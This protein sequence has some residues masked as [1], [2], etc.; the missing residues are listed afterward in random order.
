[1]AA[2]VGDRPGDRSQ[3]GRGGD[4]PHRHDTARPDRRP[5]QGRSSER[6]WPTPWVPARGDVRKILKDYEQR[7][8]APSSRRP[9]RRTVKVGEGRA[10]PASGDGADHEEA[11]AP[12]ASTTWRTC[13]RSPSDAS[14]RNG[15]SSEGP[16]TAW[17]AGWFG[18][19]TKTVD[20]LLGNKGITGMVNQLLT[21]VASQ[22]KLKWNATT[23]ERWRERSPGSSGSGEGR[24]ASAAA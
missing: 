21:G 13:R 7:F 19:M 14:A 22:H 17:S 18:T 9:R 15:T 4:G 16:P 10:R 3:C 5:D 1:V 12:D 20:T 23:R 6:K 8:E 24:E 11:G 2:A